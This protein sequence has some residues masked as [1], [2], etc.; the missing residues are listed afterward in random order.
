MLLHHNFPTTELYLK[1]IAEAVSLRD[2][3]LT[4]L[5]KT[6][7]NNILEPLKEQGYVESY[8][9]NAAKKYDEIKYVIT[10]KTAKVVPQGDTGSVKQGSGVGKRRIGGR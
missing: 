10:R 9:R 4:N 7:E 2:Q 1:T 5:I 3:N 6:V 8:E